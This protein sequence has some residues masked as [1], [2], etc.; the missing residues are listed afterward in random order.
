MKML[1][2]LK[3]ALDILNTLCVMENYYQT[4][5]GKGNAIIDVR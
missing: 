2:S 4:R 3:N 1:F 5:K